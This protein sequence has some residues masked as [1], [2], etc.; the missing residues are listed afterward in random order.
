MNIVEIY[1][2]YHIPRDL[3]LHM[4]RVA[5]CANLIIDNWENKEIDKKSIIRVCLLHDMGNLAKIK[6]NPDNDED[7]IR[8][9]TEYIEKFGLDDHEISLAIGK[10]MGLNESELQ[11]MQGKESKRNEEIMN[12]DS[13]EIKICAY[14]DE[15]VSPCGV[16]SIKDRLEDAKNRYKGTKS[17]WGNEE[18]ANHLIEC[19]LKIENQIMKYCKIKPEEINDKNIQEYIERLKEYEI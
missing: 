9:R 16:Q 10:E 2:Q 15:R 7:F 12:A 8:I 18:A 6:D 4:L 11:I 19:A 1:K 17:I 3:Q 13:F 14:C 5:S